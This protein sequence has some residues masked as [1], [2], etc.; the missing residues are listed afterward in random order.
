MLEGS[1][2]DVSSA[3]RSGCSTTLG[4]GLRMP[5]FLKHQF[6]TIVDTSCSLKAVGATNELARNA[7]IQRAISVG[8]LA[9][10][11]A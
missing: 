3:W 6:F 11:E 7:L 1:K 8:H 5:I 4:R 2:L 9:R 10:V